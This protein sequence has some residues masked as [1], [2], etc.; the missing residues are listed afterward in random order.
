MFPVRVNF[1][2]NDGYCAQDLLKLCILY[3]KNG[4]FAAYLYC[5]DLINLQQIAICFWEE[6]R[7]AN[8]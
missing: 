8:R 4:I 6:K 2:V 3:G 5:G 7:I 1:F